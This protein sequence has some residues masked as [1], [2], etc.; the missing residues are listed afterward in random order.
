MKHTKLIY[1][2]RNRVEKVAEVALSVD[3]LSSNNTVITDI[4]LEEAQSYFAGDKSA[5]DVAGVIQNRVTTYIS[6]QSN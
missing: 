1:R 6:E 3:K 2:P 5:Q 4:V